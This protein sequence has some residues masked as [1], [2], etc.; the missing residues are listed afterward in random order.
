MRGGKGKEEDD[1]VLYASR[2][3]GEKILFP[4]AFSLPS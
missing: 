2:E 4:I 1:E 3:I